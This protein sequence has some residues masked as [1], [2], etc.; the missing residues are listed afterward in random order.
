M[1]NLNICDQIDTDNS[2]QRHTDTIYMT[3]SE[4]PRQSA[5]TSHRI[6][7]QLQIKRNS[8][9]LHI[10]NKLKYMCKVAVA[11]KEKSRRHMSKPIRM[12]IQQKL[13]IE[14]SGFDHD[15]GERR[16]RRWRRRRRRTTTTHDKTWHYDLKSAQHKRT[17]TYFIIIFSSNKFKT[18]FLLVGGLLPD[19]P[20]ARQINSITHKHTHA[21][22]NT[23]LK[24]THASFGVSASSAPPPADYVASNET[25]S[26]IVER[27]VMEVVFFCW[28]LIAT[29]LISPYEIDSV[30][31]L[32]IHKT[33]AHAAK[34]T[35]EYHAALCTRDQW[36]E[37]LS[38]HKISLLYC[39]MCNTA[40]K[41][42]R[43]G[44]KQ[45]GKKLHRIFDWQSIL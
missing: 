20:N 22:S 39:A 19:A 9:A 14:D 36:T 43:N 15:E 44:K 18:K 7:Y 11:C 16:W 5:H 41:I 34:Q 13:H 42:K 29:H 35:H 12:N 32:L 25:K 38:F 26:K 8:I 23:Q 45:N 10:A 30:R 3:E 21:S 31:F 1:S 2:T 4:M 40:S 6:A 27:N 24:E 17:I 28:V 37:I 33:H